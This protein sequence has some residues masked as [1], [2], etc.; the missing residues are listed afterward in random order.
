MSKLLALD[1]AILPPPHVRQRSMKLSA[2]LPA[3]ESQGLRL[4][5]GHLPHITVTQQFVRV[6][7]LDAVLAAVDEA[8]RGQPP[9]TVRVTGGGQSASSVWMAVE[10]TEALSQLHGRLMEELRRFERPGGGPVA[11]FK[12]N[13]RAGDVVWV[14]GYRLTSSVN[15]YTP[16]ITLGHASRPPTV[17]PFTFDAT[18]I[19]ACHLGRFCSCRRVLRSWELT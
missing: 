15:A 1:V 6:D 17:D 7:E 18:T 2:T 12:A 5:A 16:H 13:A 14:A 19:A 3:D 11:F 8:L 10:R 4:D 9:L